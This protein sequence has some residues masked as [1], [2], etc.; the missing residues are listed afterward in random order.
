MDP[1]LAGGRK[2]DVAG[3]GVGDAAGAWDDDGLVLIVVVS[4]AHGV[5]VG[6]WLWEAIGG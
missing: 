2:R 1:E 3:F 5:D 4:T 6:R